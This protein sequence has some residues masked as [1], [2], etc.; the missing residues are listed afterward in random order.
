MADVSVKTANLFSDQLVGMTWWNGLITADERFTLYIAEVKPNTTYTASGNNSVDN[1][2]VAYFSVYPT[3]GQSSIDSE[4]YVYPTDPTQSVATFTTPDDDRIK[5]AAVRFGSD[6]T[7][8]MLNLGSTVL[9]DGWRH[10]L[11]KFNASWQDASIK[12]WAGGQNLFDFATWKATARVTEG[13]ATW[14]DANEAITITATNADCY[15]YPY[16][17]V[18]MWD[19]AYKITVEPNTEYVLSWSADSDLHGDTRAFLDGLLDDVSIK[20]AD[21]ANTKQLAFRTESNTEV[22]T[23]RFGVSR[24]GES[25]TYSNIKLQ[26][27]GWI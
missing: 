10:S 14:D 15:T 23:I 1:I 18:Y 25:I 13:Y 22:V 6:A 21:N 5:Y 7:N 3:E 9:P 12:E 8:V 16:A 4:R 11:Y 26:K 17:Q 2:V 20:K 24:A 27:K 19:T